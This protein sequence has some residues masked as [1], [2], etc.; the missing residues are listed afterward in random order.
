ML[1]SMILYLQPSRSAVH[2]VEHESLQSRVPSAISP[3]SHLHDPQRQR[4]RDSGPQCSFAP[5]SIR[6]PS[7]EWDLRFAFPLAEGIAHTQHK[8]HAR[9][10]FVWLLAGKVMFG[11]GHTFPNDNLLQW[12]KQGAVP[13]PTA[14]AR[15][16][17]EHCCL[18]TSH[19]SQGH[20]LCHSRCG[21]RWPS[22]SIAGS[23]C[24]GQLALQLLRW[25]Q[26]ARG[27]EL[28]DSSAGPRGF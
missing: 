14:E 4:A 27:P 21:F 22:T 10:V 3:A 19:E 6:I 15:R 23:L 18:L 26:S 17:K 11:P 24:L 20:W 28:R 12:R 9:C 16:I 8:L 5:F 7:A 2:V 1:L 25:H 13:V